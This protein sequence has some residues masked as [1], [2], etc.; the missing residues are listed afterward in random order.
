MAD[1]ARI[2]RRLGGGVV[3]AIWRL[4]YASRF[5]ATVLRNSSMAFRRFSLTS[6][7]SL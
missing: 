7:R 5:V 1:I 4:G 6:T 2:L 3:D